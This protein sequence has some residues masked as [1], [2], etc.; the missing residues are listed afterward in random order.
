[1]AQNVTMKIRTDDGVHARGANVGALN[2]CLAERETLFVFI[3]FMG[4]LRYRHCEFTLNTGY[5]IKVN[6]CRKRKLRI[7]FCGLVSSD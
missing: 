4:H 3:S 6:N 2:A 7:S 5:K 1:M